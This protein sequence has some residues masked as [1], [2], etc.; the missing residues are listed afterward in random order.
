MKETFSPAIR[1]MPQL[2]ATIRDARKAAKLTQ[3]ELAKRTSIPRSWLAQ[4]ENG[5]I[6]NPGLERILTLFSALNITWTAQ[7]SWDLPEEPQSPSKKP[8]PK[9]SIK[10]A[11]KPKT[12]NVS[13]NELANRG[14]KKTAAFLESINAK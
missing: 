1:S 9:K 13:F 6:V 8:K 12:K 10:T 3:T 2:S 14:E 11:P 5:K 7:Y 4:L